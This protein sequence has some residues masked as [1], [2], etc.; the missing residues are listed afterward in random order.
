MRNGISMA[1]LGAAALTLTLGGCGKSATAGGAG[2]P[3][4]PSRQSRPMKP[5]G[6]RTSRRRT[7]N[8]SPAIT[9]T[10]PSSLRRG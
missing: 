7:R 2:A 3:T 8:C 5:S 9:P 6:T 10:T 4:A 1:L